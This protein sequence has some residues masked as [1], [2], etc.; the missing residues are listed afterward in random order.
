MQGYHYNTDL[1]IC[2][3]ISDGFSIPS[4]INI[5]N[6]FVSKTFPPSD[7]KVC[8][9]VTDCGLLPDHRHLII[10]QTTMNVWMK[11]CVS[12][13]PSAQIHLVLTDALVNKALFLTKQRTHAKV[14]SLQSM[15]IDN[16]TYMT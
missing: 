10:L 14:I 2:E 5:V 3:G 15:I 4:V 12:L 11:I 7:G 6:I 13:M 8:R 16:Q 9:E 1:I